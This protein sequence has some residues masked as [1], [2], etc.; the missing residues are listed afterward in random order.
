MGKKRDVYVPASTKYDW[1][2]IRDFC[3]SGATAEEAA[4]SFGCS[5]SSV[6][7]KARDEDWPVKWL[8]KR[9]VSE[10]T[11]TN[12]AEL[13]IKK[14]ERLKLNA[15]KAVSQGMEDFVEAEIP[16]ETW[17]D[18]KIAMEIGLMAAGDIAEKPVINLNFLAPA[19][20]R[21]KDF[22]APVPV[23]AEIIDVE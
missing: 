14:T 10:D 5:K 7:M 16:I 23:E 18:A 8:V 1:D 22:D 17:K 21:N 19:P 9:K 11:A 20:L 6:F 4:R 2:A 12:A 15:L 3:C 13:I